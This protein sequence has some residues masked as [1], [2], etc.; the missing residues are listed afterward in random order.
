[1]NKSFLGTTVDGADAY[2]Y[3]LSNEY[4]TIQVTDFGS[5]LVN[6]MVPDKNGKLTDICL[7][8]DNLADYEN[9]PNVNFGCNVGRNANRIR[10]CRFSINDVEYSLEA[11]D[12]KNNLH[13]GFSPYSKRM[14][15]V[16]DFSDDSIT[17][18]LFSPHMDQGFPGALTLYITY[19]LIDKGFKLIYSATP[20]M[21]TIINITN[22]SYFNLNGEGCGNI[23][24]HMLVVNSD[25]FTYNDNESIPT[26]DI[27]SVKGTP[28][29]FLSS[30]AVGHDIKAD[31]D[32]LVAA[33]GYDHNWCI[34]QSDFYDNLA[35]AI[36][37]YS[38]E[39]GILMTM[40]TDYPG[41][42]IYTGNY[43][44]VKNG[45]HGHIYSKQ[46]AICFEPQFYPDSINIKDFPSP[47][48]KANENYHKEIAYIFD[49][50]N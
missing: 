20:D 13:S 22:H 23:L 43:T 49:I 27:L 6:L 4:I 44:D 1:M 35:K 12:G 50:L 36:E 5:T 25:T 15:N 30:K 32:T 21:D 41:I 10:G 31:Y 34:N 16:E 8:Y 48:C 11:N 2:L 45:K 19:Q 38:K 24:D 33:K 14:W 47:I 9:D 28:M 37:I 42:Q 7:G 18:S 39:T 40:Y 3:T 17:F 26:G 29:D 46:E